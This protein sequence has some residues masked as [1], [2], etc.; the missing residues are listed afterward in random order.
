MSVTFSPDDLMRTQQ[1]KNWKLDDKDV[2][3]IYTGLRDKLNK[4]RQ[5]TAC[6]MDR[7]NIGSHIQ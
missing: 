7:R 1:H 4:D 3:Q 6:Q 2:N 5:K